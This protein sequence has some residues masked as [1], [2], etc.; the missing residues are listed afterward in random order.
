MPLGRR[1]RTRSTSRSPSSSG[2]SPSSASLVVV[3]K[4]MNERRVMSTRNGR[5][6]NVW[7]NVQCTHRSRSEGSRCSSPPRSTAASPS[8]PPWPPAVT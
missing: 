4:K 7:F 2:T 8:S 1:E 3:F 5:K 6:Q